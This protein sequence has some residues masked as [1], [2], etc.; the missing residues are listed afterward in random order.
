MSVHIQEVLD[1]LDAHP[2][3]GF[4]G[5]VESLL[6][7]LHDAYIAHNSIDSEEIHAIFRKLDSYLANFPI[8]ASEELNRLVCSLCMEHEVLAFSHGIVVGMQL[9]TEVNYLP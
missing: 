4:E 6:E 8:G 3:G 7:M 1:Y 5:N 2:I 9:M